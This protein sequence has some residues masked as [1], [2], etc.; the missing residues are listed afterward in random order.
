MSCLLWSRENNKFSLAVLE[1]FHYN[2]K[3][4]L[5]KSVICPSLVFLCFLCPQQLFFISSLFFSIFFSCKVSLSV[6]KGT[7]KYNALFLY[8]K[9]GIK[10]YK[11]FKEIASLYNYNLDTHCALGIC[12]LQ[13]FI[14]C[15]C[16]EDL[17]LDYRGTNAA[18]G[19][20]L[21]CIFLGLYFSCFSVQKCRS[22]L[23]RLH[24]SKA[25][26]LEERWFPLGRT[27]LCSLQFLHLFVHHHN[28]QLC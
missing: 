20:F 14:H 17:D 5:L 7:N 12:W 2:S 26:V 19:A 22:C 10:L 23:I 18:C 6:L 27:W 1:Y 16:M 21:I 25:A 3:E 15:S 9:M 24:R 28:Y 11:V 8:L 13:E 4:H